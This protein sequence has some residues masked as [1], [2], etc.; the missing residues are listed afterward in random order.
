MTKLI[1]AHYQIQRDGCLNMKEKNGKRR[2]KFIA[3]LKVV[4]QEMKQLTL[5][6]RVELQLHKL[7]QLKRKQISI[8]NDKLIL[9]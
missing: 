4:M 2:N 6:N 3:E 7:V 9:N 8:E 5:S 1:L